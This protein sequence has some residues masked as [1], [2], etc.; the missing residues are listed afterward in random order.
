MSKVDDMSAVKWDTIST[1][2]WLSPSQYGDTIVWVRNELK[3]YPKKYKDSSRKRHRTLFID[4]GFDAEK[5]E[6]DDK[7][8][9]LRLS[10]WSW[11]QLEQSINHH[12]TDRV[13]NTLPET[14]DGANA[15]VDPL[16]VVMTTSEIVNSASTEL[17]PVDRP[18]INFPLLQTV[19]MRETYIEDGESKERIVPLLT[20]RSASMRQCRSCFLA[21]KC[22]AFDEASNCAYD[23]PVEIKSRDQLLALQN[24]LIEMQTQRIM[25]MRMAEDLEGGYADPN[26]SSEMDRLQKLVKT[27]H[28]MEQEGFS[29]KIEARGNGQ[30]GMISRLFGSDAGDSRKALPATI[31]VEQVM[32]AQDIEFEE[33]GS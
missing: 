29:L 32:E 21:K 8:E 16:G 18:L 2:S 9:L 14:D 28:E 23:M 30:A 22:P 7:D 10:I 33:M 19:G 25:F 13:V 11:L 31:T 3:R 12:Q 4:A 6:A 27:K 17:Q 20:A 15:Q 5:I 26:L 24:T 1:I